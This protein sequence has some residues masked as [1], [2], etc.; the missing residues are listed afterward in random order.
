MPS[1]LHRKEE[2]S[3][4]RFNAVANKPSSRFLIQG[5]EF[6]SMT[7]PAFLSGFIKSINPAIA[8]QAAAGSAWRSR[9]KLWICTMELSPFRASREKERPLQWNFP[10]AVPF[11]DLFLTEKQVKKGVFYS[12]NTYVSNRCSFEGK[13]CGILLSAS[14]GS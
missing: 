13:R 10:F 8:P 5:R 14:N 11:L 2:Q 3:P 9:N 7:N 4:S 12:V 6:Q 1:N